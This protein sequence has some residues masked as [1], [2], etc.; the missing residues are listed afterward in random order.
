MLV[1]P[2]LPSAHEAPSSLQRLRSRIADTNQ[3]IRI[4]EVEYA[5]ITEIVAYANFDSLHDHLTETQRQHILE[6]YWAKLQQV[7][8]YLQMQKQYLHLSELE[9]AREELVQR[10][11]PQFTQL[12]EEIQSLKPVATP[13]S[14][15]QHLL[16]KLET[17]QQH[18]Q[19]L[20]RTS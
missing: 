7:E 13:H 12:S 6:K 19:R 4:S 18:I 3:Q 17:I 10:Y 20:Q 15:E 2:S 14:P 16:T 11:T 9:L 8:R 5:V 1:N